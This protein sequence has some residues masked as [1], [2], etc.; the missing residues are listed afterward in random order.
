MKKFLGMLWMWV[1]VAALADGETPVSSTT[2]HRIDV[3]NVVGVTIITSSDEYLP[4]VVPY[5][6]VGV[7]ANRPSNITAYATN[8]VFTANLNACD[9]LYVYNHDQQKYHAYEL[10]SNTGDTTKPKEWQEKTVYDASVTG[11]GAGEDMVIA[12]M[13]Q[14]WGYGFW[15]QRVGIT[16]RVDKKVYL[17]GQVPVGNVTVTANESTATVLGKTLFG[18]PFNQAWDINTYNWSGKA[19]QW[20]TIQ[21]CGKA[22]MIFQYNGTTWVRKSSGRN[23]TTVIPAGTAFWYQRGTT[24]TEAEKLGL[25]VNNQPMTFEF[26]GILFNQDVDP[27][28]STETDG[29]QTSG[30]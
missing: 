28:T 4:L 13:T 20:D 22:S 8:L 17:A 10:Q 12:N 21:V 9:M 26:T 24:T 19:R 6:K 5:G 14:P 3:A 25:T 30:N 11:W 16:N 23:K 27:E 7:S 15:L 29:N 1:A 2:A 18:N